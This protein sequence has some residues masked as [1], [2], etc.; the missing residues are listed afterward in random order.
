MIDQ[1]LNRL[2][3][4]RRLSLFWILAL[5]GTLGHW[6]W[7]TLKRPFWMSTKDC[8]VA[9]I[10]DGDTLRAD[11]GAEQVHVRLHCLDAPELEQPP[12]GQTSRDHLRSLIPSGTRIELR[13]QDTDRYGRTVAEVLAGERDINLA[14]VRDGQAAVYR[15]YCGDLR[16]DLAEAQARQAKLGIWTKPG[17]QQTPW[18]YRHTDQ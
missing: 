8:R 5:I 1:L 13:V 11:C 3:R 16:F 15:A 9:S 14:M 6:S 2:T 7:E 12:W 18:H 10:H 4:H 17:L